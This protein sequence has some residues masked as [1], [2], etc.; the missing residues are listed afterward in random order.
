ML[1]PGSISLPL[2]EKLVCKA[3]EG[4]VL[5]QAIVVPNLVHLEYRPHAWANLAG[6]L[7]NLHTPRYPKTTRLVLE[8]GV[9]CPNEVASFQFPAV[10]HITLHDYGIGILCGSK[11]EPT[12]AVYWR[13]LESV[14]LEDLCGVT[15][16]REE[17]IRWLEKRR[18]MELSNLLV[19]LTTSND[20]YDFE[21]ISK[22]C[23]PAST[24]YVGSGGCPF[25]LYSR[26]HI[27]K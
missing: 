9:G 4:N 12:T 19:N 16:Q 27:G 26:H 3:S 5:I 18:Q 20:W 24:L 14:T 1:D 13:E 22:L 7:F 15:E 11:R 10:R 25:R 23:G 21:N 8:Q 6:N 2:L 17:L